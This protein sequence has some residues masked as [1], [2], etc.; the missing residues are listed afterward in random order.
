MLA[1]LKAGVGLATFGSWAPYSEAIGRSKNEKLEF[2]LR[3]LYD[4]LRDV[5]ILHEGGR[6]IRNLDLR[7]DLEAVAAK[8]DIGWI[9]RAV[10]KTD[11]LAELLRRNIQKTIALDDW[12]LNLRR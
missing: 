7:R 8:V 4:L 6:E 3:L 1:L 11:E 12:I 5:M 9:A 2:Y 10:K